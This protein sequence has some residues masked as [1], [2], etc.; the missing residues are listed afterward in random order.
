MVLC[1]SVQSVASVTY[2]RGT[3]MLYY[4]IVMKIIYEQPLIGQSKGQKETTRCIKL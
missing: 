3:R 2:H 1:Y 4:I